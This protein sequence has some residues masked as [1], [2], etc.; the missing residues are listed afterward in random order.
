M[1]SRE[2]TLHLST[3]VIIVMHFLCS[4]EVPLSIR[5]PKEVLDS[6]KM[7][8]SNNPFIKGANK[9]PPT[10][11][12]AT[13]TKKTVTPT[14]KMA[15]PTTHQEVMRKKAQSKSKVLASKPLPPR[16]EVAPPP[17]PPPPP[18]VAKPHPPP[19]YQRSRSVTSQRRVLLQEVRRSGKKVAARL[20]P[21]ETIEK[22]AFRV[23]ELVRSYV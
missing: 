21:V 2:V 6:L 14:K 13:P 18:L 19:L 3:D 22:R 1:G 17:P 9:A 16:A 7:V 5:P 12:M 8:D 15:T 4:D 11:K 20:I 10:K 23:G